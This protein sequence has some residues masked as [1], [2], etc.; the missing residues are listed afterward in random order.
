MLS[1]R[2]VA[3]VGPLGL[4]LPPSTAL[5]APVGKS[6]TSSITDGT[7]PSNTSLV[8][9]G[10]ARWIASAAQRGEAAGADALWVV[11]HI[12]WGQPMLECLTTLSVVATATDHVAIGSGILQLPMRNAAIVAKEA[13]ALSLLSEGRFVL[14]VGV[15]SHAEEFALA[16]A[17][18]STRG[19][20][21]DRSIDEIRAAWALDEGHYRQLPRSESVPIWVGGSSDAARRRA[22]RRGDGWFPLFLSPQ[23]IGD[24]RGALDADALA[25]GRD[26]ASIRQAVVAMVAVGQEDEARDVG[27]R[28]LGDLYNLPPKAFARHVIAGTAKSC[29]DEI[30]RFYDAGADHVAVFIA[31][32]SAL[33]QF[34]EVAEA[35][36]ER[37]EL[38]AS[39]SSSKGVS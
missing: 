12:F 26:P 31:G 35:L 6:S 22:A 21:L 24:A 18:F 7:T 32:R 11:D 27:S 4:V 33:D 8:P 20:Q 30:A 23:E 37:H 3:A 28:W 15:G 13:T 25:F 9:K 10:V 36:S 19:K 16:G 2:G 29:A 38:V 14:G 17:T 34:E 1:D 5:D 39:G